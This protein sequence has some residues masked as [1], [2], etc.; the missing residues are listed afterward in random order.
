MCHVTEQS[1]VQGD[2]QST[3]CAHDHAARHLAIGV[4]L[5]VDLEGAGATF[6]PLLVKAEQLALDSKAG[7]L[8]FLAGFN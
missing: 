2:T 7:G 8:V 4:G 6:L 1:T 5:G 3:V